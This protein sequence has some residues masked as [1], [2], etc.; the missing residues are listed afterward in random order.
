MSRLIASLNRNMRSICS[1][2]MQC[3]VYSANQ[4]NNFSCTLNVANCC[5]YRTTGRNLFIVYVRINFDIIS[6]NDQISISTEFLSPI[7]LCSL[8][9]DSEN[10]IFAHAKY[11][12]DSCASIRS[13]LPW[14]P[15]DIR[16]DK[17]RRQ[18]WIEHIIHKKNVLEAF[19]YGIWMIWRVTETKQG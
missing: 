17:W 3:N 11:P 15:C 10:E 18:T 14:Q 19:V 9:N 13:F 7:I 1:S 16:N 5:K 6:N 2:T 12:I 8:Q 4:T